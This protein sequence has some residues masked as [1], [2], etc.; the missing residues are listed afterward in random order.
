MLKQLLKFSMGA[1]LVGSVLFTGCNLVN[2]DQDPKPTDTTDS[3]PKP[4]KKPDKPDSKPSG[5]EAGKVKG[6]VLDS[7]GRPI[8]GAKVRI[9][10]DF[11]Y[12]DVTTDAEG[13]YKSPILPLGGF[14]AVAWARITYQGQTYTLRLGMPQ[15]TDYDF[16]DSKSG[17]V[18]DFRWQLS[19]R[20]PDRADSDGEGY[21]GGTI[22]LSNG[23][24]SIY[25]ERMQQGDQVHVTLKP[26]GPLIDGSTGQQIERTFT[27]KSGNESYK[28]TDIP[29]GEYE[30]SAIRVVPGA[31]Q[32]RLL[33]GSF[34]RQSET[35][36][37]AFQPDTYGV[38]NYE[39][40]LRDAVLYMELNR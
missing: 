17:A 34:T 3:K 11:G 6:K 38:G 27:I 35:A 33:V 40:G 39:N 4:D 9:E 12:Y 18:R 23:T 29:A 28:L 30:V 21:F 2:G 19:G 16:F 24:G 15:E 1:F 32:E 26:T 20:I 14:R 10:N 7:R 13:M 5:V 22:Q 8:A 31:G 25:K 37:F 36:I